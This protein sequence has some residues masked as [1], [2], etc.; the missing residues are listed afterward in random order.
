[1]GID[2]L[3]DKRLTQKRLFSNIRFILFIIQLLMLFQAVTDSRL[4]QADSFYTLQV[5]CNRQMKSAVTETDHLKNGGVDAFYQYEPID[6]E[7]IWYMVYVGRY[8]S[9]EAAKKSIPELQGTVNVSEKS[10]RRIED[11]ISPIE[12]LKPS[13]GDQKSYT[14]HV[15]SFQTTAR[16]GKEVERL[17]QLGYDA[18]YKKRLISGN[19]WF[20]VY[21]GR[22]ADKNEARDKGEA[23]KRSGIILF[24]MPT[25][26]TG[27]MDAVAKAI[28]RADKSRSGKPEMAIEGKKPEET[29]KPAITVTDKIREPS[30]PVPPAGAGKSLVRAEKKKE[31]RRPLPEEGA[32]VL[33]RPRNGKNEPLLFRDLLDELLITHDMVKYSEETINRAHA[34]VKKSQSS[35]LPALDLSSDGGHQKIRYEEAGYTDEWR[36]Q[37][38]LRA[39]QLIT[40]FGRTKNTIQKSKSMLDKARFEHE[41]TRQKILIDGITAYLNLIRA[42]ETLK[43]YRKSEENIKAQTGIEEALVNKGAGLSSNVLQ[44]KSQLAS[45]QAI[46][47]EAEGQMEIARNR[48]RAIF[49]RVLSDEMISRLENPPLRLVPRSVDAVVETAVN[50]NPYIAIA[51]ADTALYKSEVKVQKSTLLPKLNLFAEEIYSTNPDGFEGYKNETSAGIA[52]SWNLFNGMGD[53]AGIEAALAEAAASGNLLKETRHLI[54][55]QARNAW[56][57]LDTL[58]ERTN[59]L[60]NQ[61]NI[62]AEF[63]VLA[64]KERTLGNRTLLDILNGEITYINAISN[65]ISSKIDTKIAAYNLLYVTGELNTGML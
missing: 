40:D 30:A 35:R 1:M 36:Q 19:E 44:A 47:T 33:D 4:A 51:E 20:R 11:R 25:A 52:L 42:R 39:T 55:E 48:F 5:S 28:P 37:S 38:S 32:E 56:Q 16:A 57:K 41:A 3:N 22:F 59:L 63:L 46:V 31:K 24:Y 34:S 61:S 27:A 49:K 26:E 54:E 13:A 43:Y 45:A 2:Q 29:S 60:E 8:E 7:G 53:R 12:A 64:R 58:T 15:S 6:G 14:L 50:K 18:Y 10:I 23:L 9:I 21:M 17:K 65:A 62:A